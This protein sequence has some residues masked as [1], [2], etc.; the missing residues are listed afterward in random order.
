[1]GLKKIAWY[2]LMALLVM[3][4]IQSPNEAAKVVK[5]LGENAGEWFSTASSAFSEFLK[6]LV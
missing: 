6:S 3:F 2:F 5:A 1:M 4:L